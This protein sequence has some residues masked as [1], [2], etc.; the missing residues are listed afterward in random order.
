MTRPADIAVFAHNPAVAGYL[1][2]L[3]RLA[4]HVP[5]I[6]PA[7]GADYLCSVVADPVLPVPLF[8]PVLFLGGAVTEEGG[9]SILPV[10]APLRAADF[11]EKI[12]QLAQDARRPSQTLE[13]AGGT[14]DTRENLWTGKDGPTTRLTEKETAILV[15][16]YRAAGAPVGRDDLLSAVWS[17]AETVQTHTL[18]THIY[19]L[20]QKIEKDPSFPQILLTV[21]EGYAAKC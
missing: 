16:L 9:H 3:V 4:G 15:H 20:R 19:R 10:S 18:E 14:L 13:F 12:G 17:Y 1:C 6:K 8:S 2:A 21:D 7:E 11:I 5:H